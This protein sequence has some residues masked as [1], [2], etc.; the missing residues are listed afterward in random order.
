MC[1]VIHLAYLAN[2]EFG[3]AALVKIE[4]IDISLE[5]CIVRSHLSNRLAMTYT[6]ISY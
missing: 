4:D 2:E 3:L 5:C 6:I 1:E